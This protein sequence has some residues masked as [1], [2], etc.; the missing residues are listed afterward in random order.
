MLEYTY[1]ISFIAAQSSNNS[2]T[3]DEQTINEKHSNN[4]DSVLRDNFSAVHFFTNSC[5]VSINAFAAGERS[6]NLFAISTKSV[7]TC[8]LMG[9]RK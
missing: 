1:N 8:G 6:S 9:Y 2:Q 4:D 3:V 7:R 5:S